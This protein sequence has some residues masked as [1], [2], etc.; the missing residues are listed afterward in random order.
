M[1]SGNAGALTVAFLAAGYRR[2]YFICLPDWY[3]YPQDLIH[4]SDLLA[5]C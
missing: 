5:S 2:P 4:H 3:A 1:P